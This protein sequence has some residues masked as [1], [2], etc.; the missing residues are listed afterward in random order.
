MSRGRPVAVSVVLAKSRPTPSI[1]KASEDALCIPFVRASTPQR[2]FRPYDGPPMTMTSFAIGGSVLPGCGVAAVTGP[3]TP[4]PLEAFE[5]HG[6]PA[7]HAAS[8]A[9]MAAMMKFTV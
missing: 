9:R 6:A 4:G 1:P 8:A 5:A 3:L 2:G 7:L